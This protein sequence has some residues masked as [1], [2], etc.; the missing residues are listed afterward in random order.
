MRRKTLVDEL[1]RSRPSFALPEVLDVGRIGERVYAVER[2]LPGR[3]VLDELA[4]IRGPRR[5]RLVE[6]YMDVVGALG[7]LALETRAGFGD[8][9]SGAPITTTTWRGFLEDRAGANLSRSLP[10]FAAVDARAI[11]AQLPD[12][13]RADFVH[14]DAFAGNVLTD[15][16]RITA[17]LD[18]GATSL[19]GDRRIDPL[20]AAVYLAS[21]TI[22]PVATAAD[23][24]VARSW[25]RA[26]GLDGWFE[27]ARRWL[28]AY[29]SFAFDD[30]KVLRFC[31]QV[32]LGR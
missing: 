29:W 11:A 8:L 15:G 27:P 31:R 13:P 3:S 5:A 9:M 14:L 32:L 18:V 21:P 1:A 4:T 28:G 10:E 12:A 16:T 23:V 6:A 24:A 2:R 19:A 22:T 7:D 17:V 26:A 20:S 25:L 30:P